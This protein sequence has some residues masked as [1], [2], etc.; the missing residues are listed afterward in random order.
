MTASRPFVF[1]ELQCRS[2]DLGQTNIFPFG[3]R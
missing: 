1:V 3:S 2:L